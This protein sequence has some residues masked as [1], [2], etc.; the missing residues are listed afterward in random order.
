MAIYRPLRTSHKPSSVALA[1][2]QDVLFSD[3]S[4][5][6]P[7]SSSLN[8]VRFIEVLFLSGQKFPRLRDVTPDHLQA[9][10]ARQCYTC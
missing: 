1:E 6:S 10:M 5:F 2:S 3:E 4:I 8:A 9:D 7:F